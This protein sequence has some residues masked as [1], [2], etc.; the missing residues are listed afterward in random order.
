MGE[1]IHIKNN[2]KWAYFTK[3]GLYR[4]KEKEKTHKTRNSKLIFNLL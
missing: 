1:Q 2:F 3:L 4:I